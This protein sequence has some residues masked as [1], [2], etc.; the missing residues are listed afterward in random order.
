MTREEAYKVALE[1]NEED[2]AAFKAFLV[3]LLESEDTALPLAF[4]SQESD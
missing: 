2:R 4:T 1:M 3:A